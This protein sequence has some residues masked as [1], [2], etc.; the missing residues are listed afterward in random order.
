MMSSELLFYLDEFLL[1]SSRLSTFAVNINT[2][3]YFFLP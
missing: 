3:A 2:H 1:Y